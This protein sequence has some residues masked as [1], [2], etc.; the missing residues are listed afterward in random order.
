[1]VPLSALILAVH[2]TRSPVGTQTSRDL[3]AAVWQQLPGV[4]VRLG[5][6][7]I[8]TPTLAETVAEVGEAIVVPV[9]LT[10]GYHVTCDIPAAIDA[11]G[12]SAIATPLVGPDLLPAVVERLGET[13]RGV[14]GVVLAAA[15]S[16]RPSAVAEVHAAAAELARVVDRPTRAGFVTAANPRVRHAV[17]ALRAEGCERVAIAPYLLAPGR[18]ASSLHQAGA[19]LV[20]EPIGL[21]PLLVEVIVQRYLTHSSTAA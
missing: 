6:V 12:G 20:A 19:D 13:G 9:F 10:A 1:M 2:G 17:A 14:D 5:W 7:D 8:H 15:G 11:S 21:H 16:L 18:F 3:A 4:E